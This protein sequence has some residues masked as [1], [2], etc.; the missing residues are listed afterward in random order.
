MPHGKCCGFAAAK[1]MLAL[2]AY[3]KSKTNAN[4]RF[5]QSSDNLC[6]ENEKPNREI[7]YLD[8]IHKKTGNA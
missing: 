6:G 4:R 8:R 7:I 1:K 5:P 2:W 3:F